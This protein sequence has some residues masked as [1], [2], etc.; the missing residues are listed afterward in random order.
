MINIGYKPINNIL[1]VCEEKLIS[2]YNTILVEFWV[3][4]QC[5]ITTWEKN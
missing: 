5:G 2:G 1:T 3:R 4:N